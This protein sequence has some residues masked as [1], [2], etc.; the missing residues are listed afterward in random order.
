QTAKSSWNYTINTPL[1][2]QFSDALSPNSIEFYS[3]IYFGS[4]VP[5]GS[6]KGNLLKPLNKAATSSESLTTTAAANAGRLTIPQGLTAE[7]FQVMSQRIVNRV[8]APVKLTT[9]GRFKLT[10][11]RRFKMTTSG[12]RKLTT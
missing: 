10:R 7:E 6:G 11:S 12:R 2:T 5:L 4:K 8:Y 3:T 9:L 1:K